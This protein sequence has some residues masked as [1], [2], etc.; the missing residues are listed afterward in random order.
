M[1]FNGSGVYSAPSLPGTW[2]PAQV[3]GSANPTDWNIL[4][5]DFTAAFSSVLCTDGQSTVTADIPFGGHRLTDVGDATADTDALNRRGGLYVFDQQ[6][7]LGV[8]F[9]DVTD[10][11]ATVNNLT[12]QFDFTMGTTDR[13]LLMQFYDEDGNLDTSSGYSY[14]YWQTLSGG[15]SG[16]LVG[17]TSSGIALSNHQSDSVVFGAA[18]RVSIQ[19]IQ[20]VK[21]TQ[22]V[23]GCN[24]QETDGQVV[25]LTG[26]GWLGSNGPI[27]GFRL[28]PNVGGTLISGSVTTLASV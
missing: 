8:P 16:A 24:F 14:V 15:S 7:V 2:N 1:P 13:A 5:A 6:S 23:I 10:I 27:T 18:G 28:L 17:A 11:P 12:L 25:C 22:C 3:G 19:N 21:D 20:G 9:V 4:L 26:T